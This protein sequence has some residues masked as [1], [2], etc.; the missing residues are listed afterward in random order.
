MER[1]L[2][3]RLDQTRRYIRRLAATLGAGRIILGVIAALVITAGIDWLFHVSAGLRFLFLASLAGWAGWLA[4]RY[5]VKPLAAPISDLNLAMR[6]ER[7][8]PELDER[9]S[10]AVGFLNPQEGVEPTGS[11]GFR[12]RVIR[13]GLAAAEKVDFARIADARP[14]WKQLRYA[15]AAVFVAAGLC[16]A[17]PLHASIALARLFN[18]VS[19][20]EWPART[21]ITGLEFP[22]RV[23]KGDPFEVRL[24]LE[25]VIPDRVHV[26]YRYETGE[27]SG[28]ENLRPVGEAGFEGGLDAAT[29]GF[30]FTVRA[31]DAK[32]V[33]HPVAVVPAPE[34]TDIDVTLEYP[35]YTRRPAE[36][37]PAGRGHVRAVVGSV[38]RIAALANKPLGKAELALDSGAV[39]PLEVMADGLEIRGSFEVEK[40]DHYRLVLTDTEGMSNAKRSPRRFRIQAEPDLAPEV[41]LRRPG[42][43]IEV[44][45]KATVRFAGVARDD[46]GLGGLMIRYRSSREIPADPI[47]GESKPAPKADAAKAAPVADA[48]TGAGKKAEAGSDPKNAGGKTP[49]APAAADSK[50]APA[51]APAALAS[52]TPD[53]FADE[54]RAGEAPARS[55]PIFTT[56]EIPLRHEFDYPWNLEPLELQP[57]DTVRVW[58]AALDR[59]EKPG[60]NVGRSR[61]ITLRIVSKETLLKSVE[62][63]QRLLREELEQVLKLQQGAREQ[64]EDLEKAAD[65]VG[66]LNDD[67]IDQLQA[68]D[69]MQKRIREKV[70]ESE[71]SL[72]HEIDRLLETLEANKVNDLETRRRLD[73]AKSELGR[74]HEQHLPPINQSLTR[75]IKAARDESRGQPDA[76][77]GPTPQGQ[78]G[79]SAD[80]KAR[81]EAAKQA[82]GRSSDAGKSSSGG[83]PESGA[84]SKSAG[85]DSKAGESKSAAARTGGSAD[86]KSAESKSSDGKAGKSA[87]GKGMPKDATKA[88]E[89]ANSQAGADGKAESSKDAGKRGDAQSADAKSTDG[90]SASGKSDSSKS[91]DAASA[92]GKSGNAG[93]SAEGKMASS[94]ASSKSGGQSGGNEA[95]SKAGAAGK[96]GGSSESK[97]GGN[98]GNQGGEAGKA[99]S[100]SPSQGGAK[101]NPQLAR[102]EPKAGAES[103]QAGAE[104]DARPVQ[105]DLKQAAK[106]QE[107]VETSLRQILDQMEKWEGAAEVTSDL[108]E[109]RERQGEINRRSR[110][111]ADRNQGRKVNELPAD[112]K[113][114]VEA[115]A[116]RQQESA[117]AFERLKQKLEKVSN[118]MAAEDAAGAQAMKEAA[119]QAGKENVAG[120][121]NDAAKSLREN[122]TG[123]TRASQDQIA[124]SLDQLLDTVENRREAEL[125]KLAKQLRES[126]AELQKIAEEQKELLKKTRD[127]KKIADP[128]EREAELD[129]LSKRQRELQ[130]RT[131]DLARR[132]S[133][134]QAQRASR[135]AGRAAG[136]MD[137]AARQLNRENGEK[138]DGEQDDASRQLED[139]QR[140]LAKE[141]KKV[142]D[143]LANEQLQKIADSITQ[144]FEGQEKAIAELAR[145]EGIRKTNGKWTRGEA[146]SVRDLARV[147]RGLK[148]QTGALAERISA[149]KVF[150][151][152]LKQAMTR[153]EEAAGL[154]DKRETAEPT[155][156]AM[157]TARRR[158]KQ[159]IDALKPDRQP[160]RQQAQQ[161]QEGEEGEGEGEG[162]GGGGGGDGI[163]NIAQIKLLREMQLE[164]NERTVTLEKL[165]EKAGRLSELQTKEFT[166]LSKQQGAI[167]DLL[168]QLI[169]EMDGPANLD[170][171]GPPGQQPE[172]NKE[173]P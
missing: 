98:A 139:A 123:D 66:R 170:P 79:D 130:Q 102:A 165:R 24:K 44:T 160:Q 31:G 71:Q 75:A 155:A 137:E 141:R 93:K 35:K 72:K 86:G 80:A 88:S 90:K 36:K 55:V 78:R 91:A 147:E 103:K 63:A 104:P 13:D 34:M 101:E 48:K 33:W 60:P 62:N 153:M 53:P 28:Q 95:D 18:P 51:P 64:V 149:A 125:A 108:R 87:D 89:S 138:A 99:E 126:E 15:L 142:E 152:A 164:I 105:E 50:A 154:L 161:K 17:N 107:E 145:L 9:L 38:V 159:L 12:R 169:S 112:Q 26:Q 58:L 67:Q 111:I 110:E 120:R 94:D 140:E 83:Q 136:R 14:V 114:E 109:L 41:E 25:G 49:P 100:K 47:A 27:T 167:A 22:E 2:E 54:V 118:R 56:A 128:K 40:D 92:E 135:Q 16:F 166:E 46:H 122:R 158:V 134:Q 68:A 116:N 10:A 1:Q 124:K 97:Q 163:P 42:G 69:L 173:G 162:G 74:V 131:E 6:V 23:A 151:E 20:P 115:V 143:E 119:G 117:E 5:W 65:I 146:A 127:A 37:L 157:D 113:A 85:A 81:A 82:A 52:A 70:A 59:R 43:D 76:Q 106:H 21:R 73:L 57:G 129:R 4:I 133:R 148:D 3:S 132:L 45:A 29:R 150:V 84:D 171:E 11:A 144:V 7:S 121:M 168:R 19:G 156:L 8:H 61:E 32:A 39:R 96:Q 172:P 77:R 30:S